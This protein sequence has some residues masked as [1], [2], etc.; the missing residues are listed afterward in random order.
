MW[1]PHS[2]TRRLVLRTDV[3]LAGAERRAVSALSEHDSLVERAR[4]AE[5]R[6]ASERRKTAFS[7]SAFGYARA[8]SIR[9]ATAFLTSRL[10]TATANVKERFFGSFY[11][12]GTPKTE[13][14][15]ALLRSAREATPARTSCTTS[16]IRRLSSSWRRERSIGATRRY[17]GASEPERVLC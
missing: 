8:L 11:N 12:A 5:N 15:Y 14:T 1:M 6:L 16:K 17:M 7:R 2:P 13:P 9:R 3:G 10:A 4:N